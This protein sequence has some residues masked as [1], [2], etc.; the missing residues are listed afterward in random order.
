MLVIQVLSAILLLVASA[1]ALPL[2]SELLAALRSLGRT[3]PA[4]A[5]GRRPPR[6]IFLVPAHNESTMIDGCAR[7]LLALRGAPEDRRVVVI[8]DNCSDDTAA[9]ARAAGAECWERDDPSRGGKPQALAW[10]IQR[11]DLAGWDAVVVIDADTE[12][13]P[14]FVEA[15]AGAMPLEHR[16]VQSYFATLNEW[17]N[18]LTRLAGLLARCRYEVTYPLKARAGL[19][20]PLTG[21]GMIIGARILEAEGWRHFSITEN[22]EMYADF[23]ARGVG[24]GYCRGALIRSHEVENLRQGGTQR[25]RWLAGRLQVLGEYAGRVLRSGK[26]GPL[27]KLDALTELA[28]PSPILHVLAVLGVAGAAFL[29]RAHPLARAALVLAPLSLGPLALATVLVLA[30]HPEPGATVRA[31]AMV[32]VYAAWRLVVAVGTLFRLRDR[33]WKKTERPARP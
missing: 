19:N 3:R 24:I 6:L 22:W 21:N 16:L 2:L 23:T 11:L 5:D 7:S 18:W 14:G 12:V 29:L 13:D 31:L 17:D 10:A 33:T 28:A 1:L 26:I 8:A 27:Q 4:A 30:R 15:V 32:P 9:L 20:C 25:R